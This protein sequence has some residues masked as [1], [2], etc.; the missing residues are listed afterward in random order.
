MYLKASSDY[1]QQG[2]FNIFIQY[3]L[4]T[5]PQGLIHMITKDKVNAGS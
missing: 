3:S 2:L 4:A 5:S 1:D